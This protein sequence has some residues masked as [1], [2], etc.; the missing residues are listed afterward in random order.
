MLVS[1]ESRLN[2][3]PSKYLNGLQRFHWL[4]IRLVSTC[5]YDSSSIV[6][7]KHSR[8]VE[9]LQVND[10]FR[11]LDKTVPLDI[12]RFIFFLVILFTR[13]TNLFIGDNML[14]PIARMFTGHNLTLPTLIANTI[15][16]KFH[17]ISFPFYS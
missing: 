17:N 11:E 3:F 12:S 6:L 15:K 2:L 10:L 14:E 8:D 13:F 9:H 16:E 7:T 5:C 4:S 1:S